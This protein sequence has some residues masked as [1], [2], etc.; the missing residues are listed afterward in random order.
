MQRLQVARGALRSAADIARSNPYAAEALDFCFQ[1][2]KIVAALHFI[3]S[4]ALSVSA[5]MYM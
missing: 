2:A 1:T 4:Y 5:V 3:G